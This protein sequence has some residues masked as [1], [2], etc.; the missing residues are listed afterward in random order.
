MSASAAVGLR[1]RRCLVT[2]AASGIGRAVAQAFAAHGA[3]VAAV[4]RDRE[5]LRTLAEQGCLP[6][7]ADLAV[8]GGPEQALGVAREALGGIDVLVNAA[9][10]SLVHAVEDT[11]RGDIEALLA[12][13]L[14]APMALCAG[15]VPAMKA[16]RAG[17]IIT[18]ASELALVAQPG[19]AA[20][21]ASKGAVLAFTRVLAL[22]C[23]PFAI[24][25]NAICP[26]PIDTPML[27]REFAAAP[28]PTDEAAAATATVPIGRLGTAEEVAAVALFLAG[29]APALLQ[30]AAIVVDGGKTLL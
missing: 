14:L 3:R 26:G 24:R 30:G 1:D 12:I 16:A 20:Y 13:N 10:V 22:E 17:T 27:R 11:G 8:P 25:V 28:S 7:L 4:D 29:S 15:V 19:F 5:G 21:C 6:L 9:G 18:I 23:A 2:G